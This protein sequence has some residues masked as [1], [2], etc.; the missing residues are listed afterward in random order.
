MAIRMAFYDQYGYMAVA[1]FRSA[2]ALTLAVN[3]FALP[4]T[5]Y[6]FH[7]FP[8]MGLLYNLFFPFLV[9]VSMLLLIVGLALDLVLPILGGIIH[10]SNNLFTHFM[11]KLVYQMP[12]N[13][14]AMVRVEEVPAELVIG[15]LCASVAMGI[16]LKQRLENRRISL[17]EW[18]YI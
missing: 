14:D 8:A 11:L 10:D 7:K 4:L 1:F 2:G 5:L 6:Y 16:V 12:T 9:S 17:S 13:I 18:K 15:I 3:L